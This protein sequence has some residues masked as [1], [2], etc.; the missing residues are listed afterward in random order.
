MQTGSLSHFAIFSLT[1]DF[2]PVAKALKND[3]PF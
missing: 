3:Q 2:S 1:P